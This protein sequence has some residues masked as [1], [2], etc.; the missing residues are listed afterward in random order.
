M[1]I[2]FNF[3]TSL[4]TPN[5]NINWGIDQAFNQNFGNNLALI[6]MLS[7]PTIG[8]GDSIPYCMDYPLLPGFG[9]GGLGFGYGFNLGY[10][11]VFM[12]GN[13]AGMIQSWQNL[14][15][16]LGN[17]LSAPFYKLSDAVGKF[18]CSSG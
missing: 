12:N 15:N 11:S 2:G 10:P 1:T 4:L 14:G 16:T 6:S 18:F 5:T 17:S 9:L 3:N 7:M 13:N 8:G